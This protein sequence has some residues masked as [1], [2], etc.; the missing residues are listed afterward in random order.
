[1][2]KRITVVVSQGQSQSPAKR[3]LEENLVAALL[4][5]PGVDVVVVPHLYDLKPEG[6]GVLA[7][8]IPAALAAVAPGLWFEM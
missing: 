1:M 2:A 6:T 8:Q 5:E 4:M 3:N 7:L